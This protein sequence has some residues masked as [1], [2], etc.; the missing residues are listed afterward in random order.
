MILREYHIGKTPYE[1][2]TQM[3]YFEILGLLY[4][5]NDHLEQMN[6]ARRQAEIEQKAKDG[7]LSR[8]W[9]PKRK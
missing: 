6:D 8:Y 4:A 2:I 3:Q 1:M 7:K 9:K 5:S